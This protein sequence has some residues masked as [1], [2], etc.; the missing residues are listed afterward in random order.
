[1][2]RQ[3]KIGSHKTSISVVDG[4]T[5]ITYH[6]TPV[7]K[8]ENQSR[9]VILNSGGFHTNTTKTRMNQASNQFDLGYTVFQKDFEWYVDYKGQILNF[10]DNMELN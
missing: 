4:F 3:D 10:T 7:V 1:M 5:V 9:K 2:A 6:W 8:I